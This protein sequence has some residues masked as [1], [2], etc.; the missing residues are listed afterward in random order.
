MDKEI[1]NSEITGNSSLREVPLNNDDSL[2]KEGTVG[3][4]GYVSTNRLVDASDT[5]PLEVKWE[6]EN[7]VAH[8]K[9]WIVLY[10]LA[11]LSFLGCGSFLAA[12][13]HARY[14]WIPIDQGGTETVRAVS[15]YYRDEVNSC[16]I[17]TQTENGNE[18]RGDLC[19]ELNPKIGFD[20]ITEDIETGTAVSKFEA[21]DGIFVSTVPGS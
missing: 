8:D 19:A 15:S 12:G 17:R 2:G 4:Q 1:V 10:L 3:D 16:C 14:E 5:V 20:G 9:I 11:Y 18:F 6:P 21:G 13:A 7:R